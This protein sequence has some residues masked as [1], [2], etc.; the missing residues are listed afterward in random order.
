M[1][2]IS[3]NTIHWPAN[4]V[5][6]AILKCGI[7][8]LTFSSTAHLEISGHEDKDS[9]TIFRGLVTDIDELPNVYGY[10]N[11]IAPLPHDADFNAFIIPTP[12][13][14]PNYVADCA[15]LLTEGYDGLI[16]GSNE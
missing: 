14:N 11:K 13:I 1:Y 7:K 15:K 2:S 10:P 3:G 9:I 4:D 12:H 5:T 6:P 8:M 16:G